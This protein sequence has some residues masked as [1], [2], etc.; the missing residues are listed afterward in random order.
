MTY[1]VHQ[2]CCCT[3]EPSHALTC[4]RIRFL[5]CLHCK[6]GQGGCTWSLT[7]GTGRACKLTGD[8]ICD[9]LAAMLVTAPL[10]AIH[11]NL[12]SQRLGQN[13]HIT[14]ASRLRANDLGLGAQC[15]GS[16]A[17]DGPRIQHSLASCYI[18]FRFGTCVVE[19]LDELRGHNVPFIRGHVQGSSQ[20]HQ[21]CVHIGD[22]HCVQI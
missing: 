11:G 4:C 12:C 15:T 18:R 20:N 5:C 2:K 9:T 3:I 6:G 1:L 21:H 19:A 7:T 8:D 10:L 13:K 22:S 14:R 16:S 17:N